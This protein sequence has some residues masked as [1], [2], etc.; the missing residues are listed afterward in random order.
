[1]QIFNTHSIHFKLVGYTLLIAVAFIGITSLVSFRLELNRANSH[2]ELA[3]NQILDTIEPTIATAVYKNDIQ[4]T[5]ETLKGLMH[6]EA[7]QKA[8]VRSDRDLLLI[9]IKDDREANGKEIIRELFSP[10]ANRK[11][12]G[13]IS[14]ITDTDF[15]LQTA[16]NNTIDHA[17]SS[18]T[19]ILLLLP[20]LILIVRLLFSKPLMRI[21][22]DLIDIIA[23]EQDRIEPLENS[24]DDEIG[25]LIVSINKILDELNTKISTQQALRKRVEAV[26]KKLRNIFQSTSAGLFLLDFEGNILTCTPTLL[27]ILGFEDTGL[28]SL[29]GQN[30][31]AM[32]F[33]EPTQFQQMMHNVSALERLET[34]DL[35]LI[36]DSET[37]PLWVHCL[38][39]KVEVGGVSRFEGVIFDISQRVASEKA[40]QREANYDALTGLLR[41]NVAELRLRNYLADSGKSVVVLMLDLDGFKKANDTYGHDAGDMVLKQTAKQLES[42][43][44]HNDI[45]CRLG[46]DEFLIILFNCTLASTAF[47]IAEEI[48]TAIRTPV[49][50]NE[51]VTVNVGVSIGIALFPIHGDNVETLLKAADDA[52]YEVKRNGKNG[53]AIKGKDGKITVTRPNPQK[54]TIKLER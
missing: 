47:S 33:K 8:V 9:K 5:K 29:N 3:V 1:M 14:V 25:H 22:D 13:Q 21:S 50:I 2:A 39:S 36:N 32:F 18:L 44:R 31:A 23:G 49:I 6:H 34:Q 35:R 41:R 11:S 48:I 43:V 45:V 37:K 30:F 24:K 7:I 38:L 28:V 19:I 51:K 54:H 20:S 52:M 17:I 12:I 42:C 27:R 15:S 53:Y 40:I 16:R 4:A 10:D 26:E 46:G